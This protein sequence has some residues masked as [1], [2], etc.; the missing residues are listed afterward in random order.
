MKKVKVDLPM[1]ANTVTANLEGEF[2]NRV[3]NPARDAMKLKKSGDGYILQYYDLSFAIS[4]EDAEAFKYH[5]V[6]VID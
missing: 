3:T 2:K 5:C 6:K 4:A 1:G